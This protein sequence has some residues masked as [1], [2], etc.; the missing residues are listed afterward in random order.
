[1][2]VKFIAEGFSGLNNQT[3]PDIR[4]YWPMRDDLY[5]IDG[6]PLK[7]KKML[8]PKA[9]RKIVLKGLHTTHN[10]R[11]TTDVLLNL[12]HA[13]LKNSPQTVDHHSNQSTTS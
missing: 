5:L 1:M 2:L 6:V 11:V 10:Q 4:V 7:G 9:L 12:R 3:Q 13:S 8:V